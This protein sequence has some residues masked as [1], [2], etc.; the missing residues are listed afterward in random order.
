MNDR[1][2]LLRPFPASAALP[3]LTISTNI[4]RRF[5]TLSVR[6]H[7]TGPLDELVIPGLSDRPARRNNLWEETCLE[8]FLGPDNADHYWEFNLSPAGHWNIYH[9]RSYRKGMREEP[10]FT[11]LPFIVRRQQDMFRLSLE[12]GLDKIIPADQTVDIGVSALIRSIEGE[13][14]CWALVHTGTEADFHRRDSFIIK[15]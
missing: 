11:S 13:L 3:D 12:V 15:V 2:F 9:F 5:N 14:T 6:Y 10:A 8:L 4:T 7:L 1:P